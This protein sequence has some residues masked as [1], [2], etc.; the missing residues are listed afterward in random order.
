MMFTY[1][2]PRPALTADCIILRRRNDETQVLLVCRNHPPF[3]GMWALPGGFMEE[4]EK[5]SQTAARELFEETGLEN[6]TL[7]PF[8]VYDA[9][10]RDPRGR[11]VTLVFWGTADDPDTA[12]RPSSDARDVRWVPLS[13]LP[14]LA[15][16]HAQILEDFF[17]SM[18]TAQYPPASDP[19]LS[20]YL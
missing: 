11:T 17:A 10:G 3:E 13:Q 15:F 5:L 8:R 7:H 14:P 6:I 9:P 16:D 19:Q 1:S 18:K 4:D 12:V 20:K 2:H